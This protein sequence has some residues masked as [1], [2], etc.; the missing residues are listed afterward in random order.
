MRS[1][2]NL[3]FG[4][5]LPVF[6]F[7]TIPTP[8]RS[9]PTDLPSASSFYVSNLPDL[10][11]D[12]E[13]PLHIYSGHISSD[14]EAS[15]LP[16]TTVSAHLFFVLIKARR[17]ADKER[18]LFW[19]NASC[20]SFDGLMMET[21]PFRVDGQGGL[22]T[23]EGGW[24]EYTNM[25]FVD[26]PAGTGYSYT[27]TN[28]FVHELSSAADQVVEFMHN[29]YQIFP[30]YQQMDTY[31]GGE[32][33]AGQYI[34]YIGDA[35]LSSNLGVN[36]KGLAIGNGW[37]DARH[38]Y[39]AYLDYSVK[40]GLIEENSDVYKQIQEETNDCLAELDQI[41]GPVPIQNS[42]CEGLVT[43]VAMSHGTVID[44]Q[45]M[46]MNVYDVRLYDT[47]GACGMNWP[48][49]LPAVTKYL[50]RNDVVRAF[51]ANAKSE[52]WVECNGRVGRELRN[53]ESPSSI[54]ILPK[55]IERVPVM[56]FAG[57]QDF[58]CNYVGIES[59]I[60]DIEWAGERGLGLV[61]T[62]S[63]SVDGMPAGTWVESRGLT[64]VKIFNSSHMVPFD[65]P[66]VAQDMI[67][68]FM[69]VN[70]SSI[71]D[72]SA[73]I[74]SKVGD[75]EK[76]M[77]IV[78]EGETDGDAAIPVPAGKTPQQD[79]AMWEGS[80]ALVLVLIA[81]AIGLFLFFRRRRKTGDL[82]IGT[83]EEGIPLRQNIG[84]R[85][86]DEHE[87]NGKYK[88]KGRTLESEEIFDVGEGS[89]EESVYHDRDNERRKQDRCSPN[90]LECVKNLFDVKAETHDTQQLLRNG[91]FDLKRMS[92]VLASQRVFLFVNESMVKKYKEDLTEEIEPQILELIERTKKGMKAL[93]R[94]H[95]TMHTKAD[96]VHA[97]KASAH[98]GVE[99][100]MEARRLRILT[101]QRQDLERE[102][103]ALHDELDTLE[104][105][106][107][108][109]L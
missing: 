8:A 31:L 36:L 96:H 49:D 103:Q 94:K 68:R 46:C 22:K 70:F 83:R 91:T 51:H 39:P 55:L 101:G 40:H 26:Q 34:P 13:H 16:S 38:Q 100:R 90:L 54:T 88:G 29:F 32:S 43:S 73:R 63:W 20:S 62:K 4:L 18:I 79:K 60:S 102:L 7:L 69:G 107:D 44:G 65:L 77:P 74:P 104:M 108:V 6:C 24:E 25:V 98:R 81:L 53:R 10:H 71:V 33:Y 95:H 106:Y 19:F 84:G 61:E 14:P 78:M 64:Y 82:S 87:E 21:G 17:T 42:K 47:V 67:M 66:I 80:A 59:L 5:L 12:Q 28:R 50:G 92:R 56:L 105:G 75:E 37:I 1:T 23:V 99:S 85:D 2:W 30:E 15:Q 9:A 3:P 48:P 97:T 57:D 58:I 45:E 86:I 41:T 27:S 72:G 52:S 35:V 89:D 93:E 109:S 11:Q 76:P